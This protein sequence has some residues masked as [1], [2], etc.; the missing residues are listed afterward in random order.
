M[1]CLGLTYALGCTEMWPRVMCFRFL[2]NI[3]MPGFVSDM[4]R[5][6]L[7]MNWAQNETIAAKKNYALFT[8]S[9]AII[10]SP[11]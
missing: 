7:T 10:Y 3:D 9:I 8:T 2:S 6:H 11:H 4:P 1:E 5:L